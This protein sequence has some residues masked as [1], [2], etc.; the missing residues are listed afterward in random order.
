MPADAPQARIAADIVIVR[1]A[2][3]DT[4]ARSF[5]P[6]LAVVEDSAGCGGSRAS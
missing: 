5:A 3:D 2:A 4:F 1:E 6:G